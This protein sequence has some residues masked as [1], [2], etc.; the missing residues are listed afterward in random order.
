MFFLYLMRKK[1]F[2]NKLKNTRNYFKISLKIQKL[3]F[4]FKHV[5]TR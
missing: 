2:K 3:K 1:L 4:L 5:D